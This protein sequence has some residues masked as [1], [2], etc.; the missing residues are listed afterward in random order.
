MSLELSK[1]DQLTIHVTL[2]D[3]NHGLLVIPG[4]SVSKKVK[5]RYVFTVE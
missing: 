4:K 5:S 1:G 3:S 2:H